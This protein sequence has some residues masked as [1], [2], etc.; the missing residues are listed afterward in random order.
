[1]LG[2]RLP[3]PAFF[4]NRFEPFFKN[5]FEYS[6]LNDLI[7]F[8]TIL[9]ILLLLLLRWLLLYFFYKNIPFKNY[10]SSSISEIESILINSSN[11]LKVKK[12]ILKLAIIYRFSP[13]IIGIK[14]PYI[15]LPIPLAV[16]LSK[17]EKEILILHELAHIKRNDNI[18]SWA[19]LILRDL[20]FFNPIAYITY[21]LIKHEQ[22]KASDKL[23]LFCIKKDNR[24]LAKNI[25]NIFLK[26][27]KN[28]YEDG[29]SIFNYQ[30]SSFITSKFIDSKLL[31]FRVRS[32]LET[33]KN[34]IYLNK[35][36]RVIM[37]I[38]FII[39][40]LI[41]IVI[42]IKFNNFYIFLR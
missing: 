28:D 36:N 31:E 33:K 35:L 16:V 42:I 39:T 37:V 25:L 41:Q 21:F 20:L 10:K 34:K 15:V 11:I 24:E 26:I 18:I 8:I 40:L 29:K 12:P 5:P 32:I 23:V 4:I 14:K 17:Q 2:I 38:F 13:F 1:V 30:V 6:N 27:K 3:S 9:L 7:I 22:E 19:A